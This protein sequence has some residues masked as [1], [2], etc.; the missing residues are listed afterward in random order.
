MNYNSNQQNSVAFC[1]HLKTKYKNLDIYL[2]FL[3]TISD[4]VVYFEAEETNSIDSK[5]DDLWQIDIY[6]DN[7][8]NIEEVQSKI[9]SLSQK[10]QI[11]TSLIS[12]SQVEQIDWVSEVQKTFKPIKAGN[13]YIFPNNDNN[14]LDPDLI[15]IEISAGSAFG[16]GEHET[17]S[18]CLK[19]LSKWGASAKALDMGCGSGI[20]AIAMAKLG[21]KKVIAVDID[22]QA[23]LVT[24]ANSKLNGIDLF[25]AEQSDGYNSSLVQ[26]N[27]PYNLICSNILAKPLIQMAEQAYNNL[28]NDG[29][30]I[31]A[32]FLTEQTQE[33]LSAHEQ[34][35]LK[36]IET[37]TYNNWPAL[38]LKK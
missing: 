4:S 26:D 3:E 7:Q 17:T 24:K 12:C 33:V 32:G 27:G 31:L 2:P 18:N 19:A 38:V 28:D 10:N 16:T 36:L 20:L 21:V 15:N 1:L 8:P 30:L 9:D 14:A 29:I 35:G 5:P 22:S 37:I 34:H 11:E 13:F 25:A 23:V 6:L